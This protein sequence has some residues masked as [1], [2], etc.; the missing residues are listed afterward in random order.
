MIY[1]LKQYLYISTPDYIVYEQDNT[2]VISAVY[3]YTNIDVG[4]KYNTVA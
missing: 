1:K 3:W 2:E 4:L